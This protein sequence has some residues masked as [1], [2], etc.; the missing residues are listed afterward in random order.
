MFVPSPTERLPPIVTAET[1]V[2]VAVPVV[3][4]LPVTLAKP[5]KVFM[6]LVLKVRLLY[7]KAPTV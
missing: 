4:K 3:D 6:P 5:V 2:A 7:V 1:N